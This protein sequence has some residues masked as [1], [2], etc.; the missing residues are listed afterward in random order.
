MLVSA[1]GLIVG[2]WKL[3]GWRIRLKW[4]GAL[5]LGFVAQAPLLIFANK[6]T[7]NQVSLGNPFFRPVLGY[8]LPVVIVNAVVFFV[9]VVVLVRWEKLHSSA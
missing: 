5:C 3:A 8:S 9:L 1:V 6:V 2:L 7:Q 4:L